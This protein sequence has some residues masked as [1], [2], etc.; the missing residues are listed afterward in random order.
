MQRTYEIGVKYSST[1]LLVMSVAS[2][3]AREVVCQAEEIQIYEGEKKKKGGVMK[4]YCKTRKSFQIFFKSLIFNRTA[5]MN[6][7]G[8]YS[9][10]HS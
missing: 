2:Y 7:Y 6:L 1:S 3:K 10:C 4:I 5:Y 9:T 8:V